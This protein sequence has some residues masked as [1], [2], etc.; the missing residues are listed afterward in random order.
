MDLRDTESPLLVG[1][2]EG[3]PIAGAESTI[4]SDVVNGE[5]CMRHHLGQYAGP[6]GTA[7]VVVQGQ[8]A[9]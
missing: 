3:D 8:N 1:H 6:I 4:D 2:Y 9:G 7:A 5:L